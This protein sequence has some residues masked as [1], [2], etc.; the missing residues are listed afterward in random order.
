[1]DDPREAFDLLRPLL[2]SAGLDVSRAAYRRR[3][4]G[5]ARQMLWPRSGTER[6]E[7]IFEDD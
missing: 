1:L 3:E 6:F 4:D 2:E 7:P 5:A